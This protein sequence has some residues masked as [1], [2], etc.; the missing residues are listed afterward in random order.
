MRFRLTPRSM[1]LDYL[2]LYKFEFSENFLRFRRFRTQQQLG[3]SEWPVLSGQRKHVELEQFWACFSV[4]RVCQ[5]QLGFLIVIFDAGDQGRSHMG[6]GG[7]AFPFPPSPTR[8]DEAGP[9]CCTGLLGTTTPER[10]SSHV[11]FR[12]NRA[13]YSLILKLNQSVR[14]S[15]C[16]FVDNVKACI[17]KLPKQSTW[18]FRTVF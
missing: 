4:A 6:K 13:V 9:M 2:E 8:T 11:P 7:R 15:G 16:F 3:L 18:K 17:K 1:T 5:R 12:P 10:A 14:L